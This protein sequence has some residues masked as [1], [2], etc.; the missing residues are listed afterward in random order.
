[1]ISWRKC[2]RKKTVMISTEKVYKWINSGNSFVLKFT[3]KDTD[4]K[5]VELEE[6]KD[7]AREE[8]KEEEVDPQSEDLDSEEKDLNSKEK[9]I[10][11][12][13]HA[14]SSSKHL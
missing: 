8:R 4:E 9:D 12:E 11:Q 13:E 14:K 5:N 6:E 1:M 10:E 3:A 7:I 2:M